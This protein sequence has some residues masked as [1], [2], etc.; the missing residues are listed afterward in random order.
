LCSGRAHPHLRD[1]NTTPGVNIPNPGGGPPHLGYRRLMELLEA[2]R[3][4]RMT[5]SFSDAP[6][7]PGVLAAVVGVGRF[8]PSAGRAH[9]VELLVLTDA[10]RRAAFWEHS[11]EAR[12][13]AEAPEAPGLLRAPVIA[14][15]IA[16]PGAYER[17]YAEPDKVTSLLANKPA[18][19]WP[20]PY[21]S[22]DAAFTAMLVLLAAHDAGLGGLFFQLHAPADALLEALGTPGGRVVIGALALGW[23]AADRP[24]R[25]P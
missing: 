14:V 20:V 1:A 24:E 12:W 9:G 21:W 7:A 8:A 15:P 16:D 10:A 22:V 3:T 4:R 13:R 23:P 11:S 19:R 2:I 17:R 6:V 25:T 18:D 5:R